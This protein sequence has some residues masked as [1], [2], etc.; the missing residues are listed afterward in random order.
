MTKCDYM[1]Y[2][3][4]CFLLIFVAISSSVAMLSAKI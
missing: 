4:Y 2:L 1:F 3:T